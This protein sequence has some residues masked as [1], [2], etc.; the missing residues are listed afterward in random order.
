MLTV[1]LLLL[2]GAFSSVPQ[3][4]HLIESNALEPGASL[5]ER[6]RLAPTGW[7]TGV[8]VAAIATFSVGGAS[9]VGG[10]ISF[11]IAGHIVGGSGLGVLAPLFLGLGLFSLG[12]IFVA[13]GVVVT[14]IGVTEENQ[15]AV[16]LEDLIRQRDELRT[17]GPHVAGP[18][19]HLLVAQF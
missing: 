9:L 2:S 14:V 17:N 4:L 3:S 10:V 6:I 18:S 12:I 8:R 1:S 16:A 19:S 5:D 11:V 13:I 15:R 7:S